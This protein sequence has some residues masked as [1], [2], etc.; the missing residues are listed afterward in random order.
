MDIARKCEAETAF[1][2]DTVKLACKLLVHTHAFHKVLEFVLGSQTHSQQEKLFAVLDESYT[3]LRQA[4]ADWRCSKT[5]NCSGS[6]EATDFQTTLSH[7]KHAGG[8][9]IIPLRFLENFLQKDKPSSGGV[10][11]RP[12]LHFLFEWA[13]SAW[14]AQDRFLLLGILFSPS[15]FV[16]RLPDIS[17]GD[18]TSYSNVLRSLSDLN[19]LEQFDKPLQRQLA[20]T[21]VNLDL[22]KTPRCCVA[23]VEA[24]QLCLATEDHPQGQEQQKMLL[25]DGDLVERAT[26]QLMNSVYW[27]CGRTDWAG[28]IKQAFLFFNQIQTKGFHSQSSDLQEL[29]VF[30]KGRV[31]DEVQAHMQASVLLSQMHI[32][33][34]D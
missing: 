1:S 25:Q 19:S 15:L 33:S 12:R 23:W 31:A 13:R 28:F 26:H 3:S 24:L 11:A 4:I 29:A 14:D 10:L 16:P 27:A 30:A 18:P 8:V 17:I 32:S 5:S 20:E 22:P 6:I 2:L 34:K 21:L 9:G 7:V